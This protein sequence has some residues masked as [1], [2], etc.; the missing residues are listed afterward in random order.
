MD[1][2]TALGLLAATLTTVA[3]LPQV[4]KTWRRQS[5][6]D[7]SM[8][9]FGTF[10]VGVICWLAYGILIGDLPIILA[11]VVTLVLAGAILVLAFIFNR[12]DRRAAS[13][14]PKS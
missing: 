1:F 10:F 3:F 8:G 6:E 2:V 7:L 11:N 4:L 14:P 12:R 5:A 9:T 13:S